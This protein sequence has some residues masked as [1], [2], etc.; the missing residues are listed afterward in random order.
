M[1]RRASALRDKLAE[2]DMCGLKVIALH[3]NR[4]I[5]SLFTS[6][7]RRLPAQVSVPKGRDPAV[8]HVLHLC[9]DR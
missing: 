5:A 2:G 4:G 8:E 6:F 7:R 3:R 9:K 1:Q